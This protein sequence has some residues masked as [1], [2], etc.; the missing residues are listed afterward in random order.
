M[1]NGYLRTGGFVTVDNHR[2]PRLCG[3]YHILSTIAKTAKVLGS[4]CFTTLKQHCRKPFG[5]GELTISVERAVAL[6]RLVLSN[7]WRYRKCL[8]KSVLS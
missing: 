6:P 2:K 1:V 4:N 7:S 3:I 8:E 5:V